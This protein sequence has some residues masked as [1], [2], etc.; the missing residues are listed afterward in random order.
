MRL[1][2]TIHKVCLPVIVV[3]FLVA[4]LSAHA[5]VSIGAAA[6]PINVWSTTGQN[7]TLSSF[8]GHVLVMDFFA[9]WCKPCRLSIPHLI[10]LN[11]RYNKKGLQ[12]LGMSLDEGG[13]KAVKAFIV[14]KKINYPVAMA[15]EEIFND[16]GLRSLPTLFVLNKKG[17][18]VERYF[19]FNDDIAKSMEALIIKL[20][21]E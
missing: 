20:L 19:G 16:F 15:N 2:E 4:P 18:I 14:D 10:A 3:L 5:M 17:V 1:F 12:V 21:A 8:K 7:I 9:T 6:P 13:E 11:N